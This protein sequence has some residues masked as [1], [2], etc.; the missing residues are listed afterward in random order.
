M[1]FPRCLTSA[2]LLFVLPVFTPH[3]VRGT[4]ASLLLHGSGAGAALCGAGLLLRGNEGARAHREQQSEG[5]AHAQARTREGLGGRGGR[6]GGRRGRDREGQCGLLLRALF[7]GS[8][9]CTALCG[10][11]HHA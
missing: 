11:Q 4:P 2:S 6:G 5:P 9:A 8:S 10:K 7:Y 3:P 1:D